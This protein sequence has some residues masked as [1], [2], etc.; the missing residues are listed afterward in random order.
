MGPSSNRGA[1]S[2]SPPSPEHTHR[3]H[4]VNPA[5]RSWGGGS[6]C[7][8]GGDGGW[9]RVGE[10][11]EE[12]KKR[13]RRGRG[14]F[15]SRAEPGGASPDGNPKE[16][17]GSSAAALQKSFALCLTGNFGFTGGGGRGEGRREAEAE[18]AGSPAG[19]GGGGQPGG[20]GA[21]PGGRRSGGAARM[22]PTPGGPAF[23]LPLFRLRA[24]RGEGQVAQALSGSRSHEWKKAAGRGGPPP[25]PPSTSRAGGKDFAK[26]IEGG[27]HRVCAPLL[28]IAP[29]P[30]QCTHKGGAAP[31]PPDP[32]QGAEGAGGPVPCT[33]LPPP[34][35]MLR[36]KAPGAAPTVGGRA[37]RLPQPLETL[38][39]TGALV[40]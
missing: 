18:G 11:E 30:R 6:A 9:R 37:A 26:P 17:T 21:A 14:P 40:R 19:Q 38:L 15:P 27:K 35:G 3:H 13:W 1:G 7:G 32:Q 31:P 29:P 22:A 24:M 28:A 2:F 8:A 12:E 4:P 36:G 16:G 10:E 25:L 39:A 33:P 20:A 5:G 34:R 23:P